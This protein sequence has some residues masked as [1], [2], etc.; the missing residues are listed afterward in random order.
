M[1]LS[2]TTSRKAP[3]VNTSS[4]PLSPSRSVGR[5]F[6]CM[7]GAVVAAI[8]LAPT[9]LATGTA[10]AGVVL[11]NITG[12]TGLGYGF[13]S[14]TQVGL[15]FRTGSSAGTIDGLSLSLMKGN[16]VSAST[17]ITFSVLLY[18][19]DENS[20]P[21]GAPLSQDTGVA[22]A[23]TNPVAGQFQQQTF[24][25][26]QASLPNLFAATLSA[27]TEYV[28]AVANNSGTPAYEHYWATMGVFGGYTVSG[29]YSFTTMSRASDGTSWSTV[30][31][32]P[33]AAIS[34]TAVPEPSTIAMALAGLL[35]GGWSLLRRKAA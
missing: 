8:A 4:I 11:T 10:H 5:L 17:S 25:Y 14:P 33:V 20:L 2:I 35:C 13:T 16:N 15:G 19:A 29:G 7:R 32:S 22:A 3:L 26:G 28:L 27:N 1:C 21:S 30:P 6:A 31:Y 9:F 34:V 12:T 18:A 24:T 23:W